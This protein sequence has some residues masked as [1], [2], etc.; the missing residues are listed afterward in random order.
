MAETLSSGTFAGVCFEICNVHGEMV[1]MVGET[2]NAMDV[3]GGTLLGRK[4]SDV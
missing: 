1:L 2:R 4:V 3:C